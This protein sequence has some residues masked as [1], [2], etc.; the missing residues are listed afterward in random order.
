MDQSAATSLRN[1]PEFFWRLP[2]LLVWWRWELYAVRTVMD[3]TPLLRLLE[4]LWCWSDAVLQKLIVDGFCGLV[5]EAQ[6]TRDNEW[7]VPKIPGITTDPVGTREGL[8]HSQQRHPLNLWSNCLQP[9]Q[10]NVISVARRGSQRHTIWVPQVKVISFNLKILT[11]L[12][13]T[14]TSLPLILHEV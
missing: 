5:L 14:Q 13:H 3:Y 8:V 2:L 10:V 9:A 12:R 1:L 11:S 6:D 4:H 7:M